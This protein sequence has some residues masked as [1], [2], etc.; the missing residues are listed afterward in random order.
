MVWIGEALILVVGLI[1]QTC[2]ILTGTTTVTQFYMCAYG[3]FGNFVV[4]LAVRLL[5]L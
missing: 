4:K 5:V 3:S 2:T 1:S